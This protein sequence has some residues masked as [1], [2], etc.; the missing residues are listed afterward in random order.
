VVARLLLYGDFRDFGDDQGYPLEGVDA[1]E[2][3]ERRL[4]LVA[5]AGEICLDFAY[6]LDAGCLILLLLIQAEDDDTATGLIGE[7]GEGFPQPF[8]EG[9]GGLLG[10]NAFSV[11]APAAEPRDDVGQLFIRHGRCSPFLPCPPACLP[12][13]PNGAP[14]EYALLRR[15]AHALFCSHSP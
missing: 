7:G 8:R 11:G 10:L 14:P 2:R 3:A 5:S 13:Y 1:N 15:M 12:V 9:V 4:H 6:R